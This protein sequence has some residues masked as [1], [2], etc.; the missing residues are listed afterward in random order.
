M[1]Q[2][3]GLNVMFV[4]VY[5]DFKVQ[6]MEEK[7]KSVNMHPSE[8]ESSLYRRYQELTNQI[9]EKDMMV[10]KLEAQLEKQVGN[11]ADL[12]ET[13]SHVCLLNSKTGMV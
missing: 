11:D 2:D 7:L 4:L 3:H 9:Q 6:I 5:Y 12:R 10:K 8:S 1:F 13:H